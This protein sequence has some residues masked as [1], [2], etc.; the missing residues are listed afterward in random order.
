MPVVTKRTRNIARKPA[1]S[2]ASTKY[3]TPIVAAPM[4]MKFQNVMI[5]PPTLSASKPPS[6]RD[7]EP[8]SGPRNAIADRDRGE[9]RLDQQRER[10]RVADEGA[11]RPDI[12][13]RT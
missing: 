4:A 9:L 1:N 11:E 5:A 6:G 7:S 12:D 8:T 13:D 2:L 10:R 3:M